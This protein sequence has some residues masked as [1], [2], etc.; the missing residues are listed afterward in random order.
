MQ[1]WNWAGTGGEEAA[2][3]WFI[4]NGTKY[5]EIM[6]WNT[7]VMDLSETD[8]DGVKEVILKI[9]GNNVFGNLKFESES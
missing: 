9:S 7:E 5:S 6:S 4:K 1:Y 8:H 3:I 2:R